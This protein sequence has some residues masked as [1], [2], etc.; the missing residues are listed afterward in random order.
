MMKS[1]TVFLICFILVTFPT[2]CQTYIT[3]VTVVDVD[4]QKLVPGQTVIVTD[5]IISATGPSGKIKIPPGATVIEGKGKYLMPGLT[6]A[7][8]HFFQSGGLYARPD[9]IDLRKD[10]PYE[11]EIVWTHNNMED[12]LRRYLR[13][14]I[15]SVIDVG[16][17]ISFLQQ[18]DTFANKNYAPAIY[19]TG[20]LLTSYEPDEY[21]NLKNDE[22]FSLVK[23]GEDGVKYVQQQLPYHPDFIK[24][25]YIA[26]SAADAKKFQ[27][28][29]KA[30]IDE[31][32]KN[33][34]KVAVHATERITAQLAVESGCDYLVHDIEDE[35]VPDAFVQLLKTKK[36]IL[37]PTLI[38][39]DGYD[40]TFAQKN[41]YTLYDF[42]NA[43]PQAI[44]SITDLRH[45]PDSI[46]IDRYKSHFAS[47]AVARASAHTDS[48]RMVNL[49]K[50]S[51]AGVIIAAGTDAGNIGTQH[52]SSFFSELKTMQKS[53]MSNWQIIRSATV[54]PVK[55]FDKEKT[56][57]SIEAGKKANAILLNANPIENLENLKDIKLVINRGFVIAPDTLIKETPLALVERQ[58]NAY[59]A[60]RID[61]FLEPYADDVA[62]YDFP[63]KLLGKGKDNMRN[64]YDKLFNNLPDLHCEIQDRII[65][66]NIIIDK[67][68][69]TIGRKKILEGTV[70]YEVENNKISKVY[71]MQ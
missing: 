4:K 28:V 36:V 71:F 24:I 29:A 12:F 62:L 61:A 26:A 60:G 58:L 35:I 43:N 33:N 65:Q 38:V 2:F 47:D 18:R 66:G 64:D 49:K 14:G 57:G 21:L 34:L 19:M 16:S 54:N 27:P 8:V 45:L 67:E 15:T 30:I 41:S 53:G 48:I 25:W 51:D 11:K 55:I 22:P 70:I 37:C 44:G 1:K 10:M 7:H 69:I 52:A 9:G 50:M 56:E 13:S 63:G 3:N 20:P 17:T 31:A 40:N 6:D 39:A 23:T 46:I 68:K 32:H 59:N 42:I 5:D